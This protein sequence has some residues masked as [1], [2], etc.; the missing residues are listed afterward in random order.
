V[1]ILCVIVYIESDEGWKDGVEYV[2]SMSL[3]RH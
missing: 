2:A 3:L 1:I